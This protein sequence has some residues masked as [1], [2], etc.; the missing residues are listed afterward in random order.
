MLDNKFDSIYRSS[1]E[2]IFLE[3]KY[4]PDDTH[5]HFGHNNR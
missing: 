5:V 2:Y 1:R 4:N 3:K